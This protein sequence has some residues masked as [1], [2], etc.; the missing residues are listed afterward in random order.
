MLLTTDERL[1]AFLESASQGVLAVNGSG[2]IL[3][4]NARLEEI[5]G[6]AR[7][8]LLGRPVE[9]LVPERFRGEQLGFRKEYFDNPRKRSVGGGMELA[10]RRKDGAEFPVEVGLTYVREGQETVVLAFLPDITERKR[11]EERLREAAKFE[12]LGILAGGVAHDFN[13]LLVGIMGNASLALEEMGPGA[14]GRDLIESALRASE[15]AAELV[16]Q[17]LAYAGQGRFT[18]GPV[19][20]SQVVQRTADSIRASIPPAVE[21]QLELAPGLPAVEADRVQM[22]QLVTNLV[23]NGSEAIGDRRGTLIVRTAAEQGSPA[24]GRLEGED[25]G[26]GRA[27]P[28]RAR[29]FDP[30]FTTKFPGRGLGLA[31]VQGMVRAYAG[32]VEVETAPGRGSR[33]TVRLPAVDGEAP[34]PGALWAGQAAPPAS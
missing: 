5:F 1:N 28:P 8:E 30:F 17:L 34:K 22:Q 24:Q 7:E 19:D 25:D 29:I 31:A 4:V 12:S 20:L 2:A 18:R 10:G 6:Y 33:F 26:C 13:N 3:L 9:I 15:R 32:T 21:L 23:I 11:N 16:R 27:A 14:P